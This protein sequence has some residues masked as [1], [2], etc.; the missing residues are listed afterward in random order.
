MALLI[1]ALYAVHPV[2]VE[3]RLV[4]EAPAVGEIAIAASNTAAFALAPSFAAAPALQP[5]GLG[6]LGPSEPVDG[7]VRLSFA[8]PVGRRQR[9]ELLLDEVSAAPPADREAHAYAFAA[10]P[11][12]PGVDEAATWDVPIRAVERAIYLVRAR[13]DGVASEVRVATGALPPAI[14][15]LADLDI[16][17]DPVL[18]LQ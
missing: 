1:S 14:Q 17:S 5:P 18:D 15:A 8:H 2:Q 12:A 16:Y 13:V 7:T 6:G 11:P 4:K 10:T 3:H 9:V